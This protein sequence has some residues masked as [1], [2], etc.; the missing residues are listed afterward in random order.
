MNCTRCGQPLHE[1]DRFCLNCGHPVESAWPE[2]LSG[3]HPEQETGE[4]ICEPQSIPQP[5]HNAYEPECLAEPLPAETDPWNS[6]DPW[7]VPDNGSYRYSQPAGYH[8]HAAPTPKKK[9]RWVV[10]LVV[11]II[12]LSVAL[13]VTGGILVYTLIS[14]SI[15]DH[16]IT[17]EPEPWSPVEE[18][19][20]DVNQRELATYLGATL[21]Q[22]RAGTGVIFTE[23]DGMYSNLDSSVMLTTAGPGD[24]V[25]MVILADRDV[26][27]SICGVKIGM[28]RKE[29][30]A[31]AEKTIDLY[32]DYDETMISGEY[33]DNLFAA[34]FD[35]NG[36]ANYIM[37]FSYTS[38][39]LAGTGVSYGTGLWF[40]GET[41]DT[42]WDYLG[43]ETSCD[44]LPGGG[45]AYYYEL[46]GLYFVTGDGEPTGQS[47]ISAVSMTDGAWFS[48]AIYIGMTYDEILQ[49]VD[50]SYLYVDTDTGHRV[51]DYTITLDGIECVG[52][53]LFDPMDEDA[54]Y[55]SVSA[56][57]SVAE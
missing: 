53:F 39:D 13:V 43:E 55:R 32:I 6:E 36:F 5:E 28:D 15:S 16:E 22:V 46:D 47:R 41:L 29:V 23:Y 35:E 45:T 4:Q 42:M 57:V 19:L 11:S 33:G 1:G 14:N 38:D 2:S 17:V 8:E 21:D 40:I 24:T 44:P 20:P 12:L 50:M 10:P 27:F 9:N 31:V 49:Y 54:Q 51:A 48:D 18:V 30:R 34:Y 3:L 7:N 25:D 26:G 37:Y 52:T 56:Y